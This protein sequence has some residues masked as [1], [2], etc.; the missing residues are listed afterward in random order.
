MANLYNTTEGKRTFSGEINP[1][2]N[3]NKISLFDSW[4]VNEMQTKTKP[5]GINK[6]LFNIMET[7]TNE[8][9]SLFNTNF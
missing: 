9:N 1:A 3:D 8:E 2:N 7:A 6:Y 4:N 5:K